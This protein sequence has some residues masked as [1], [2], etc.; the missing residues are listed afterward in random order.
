MSRATI[1]NQTI[2]TR[3]NLEVMRGLEGGYFDLIYLDPPFNSNRNYEAPIGSNAAG[4]AFK[5]T[6]TLS[7]VDNAWHGEI[8][9]TNPAIYGAI[10]ASELTHGK[11]MKS[12]LIMMAIRLI[13]MKRILKPTGSVYLHCDPTAS[14]YL[15]TLMDAVFGKENFRNEIV[16]C[17]TGPGSP[18]MR[19]FNR[20]HDAI[21]WYSNGDKWTFNSDT[22]RVP[23]KKLNTNKKGAAIA[24]PLTAEE[25]NEYLKKGKIPETWWDGFS[26]V[27]R[28]K[29]E[30]TGYPTQK[31]LALLERIVSASS[32]EDD[33]VLDPFCGCATA[34]VAAEKLNRRWVGIDI[35]EKAVELVKIRMKK[36]A[37][38][39][40]RFEPIHRTD[41][42]KRAGALK[43]YADPDNKKFLYGQQ[44]GKCKGCS[45][46]FPY[47]NLTVDH[48]IPQSKGGGDDIEN[49]QL[50]CGAC[51]SMK[52]A[53]TQEQLI[54]RLK[55]AG[56]NYNI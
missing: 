4:A 55:E 45:I 44:E 47:R 32:N 40:D 12:Y 38:L 41:I 29:S 46:L 23:H 37:S 49:L 16:W 2:W 6:W 8:A 48:I 42:P 22:V 36:E 7:D 25:R 33:F 10:S 26:P 52:G 1:K 35:S 39:F 5:D 11:G 13:E 14:H 43:R 21:F 9:E 50:L 18:K 56:V 30:R 24:A 19:Q 17:Y 3:D 15:K 54:V 34:L 20:K 27:G 51:N 53:G 28:I 31:P